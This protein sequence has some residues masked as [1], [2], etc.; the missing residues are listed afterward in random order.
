M[1]YTRAG[2]ALLRLLSV[3]RSALLPACDGSAVPAVMWPSPGLVTLFCV[4]GTVLSY[5]MR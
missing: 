5:R 4:V 2:V 3:P 1:R